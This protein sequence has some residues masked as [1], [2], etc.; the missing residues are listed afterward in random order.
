MALAQPLTSLPRLQTH[1]V[2]FCM[3]FCVHTMCAIGVTHLSLHL[4]RSVAAQAQRGH[5]TSMWW[6]YLVALTVRDL[7]MCRLH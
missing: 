4:R 5:V 6:A 7:A 1:Q 2:R 3:R